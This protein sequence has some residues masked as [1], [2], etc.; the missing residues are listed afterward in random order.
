M[1]EV[2]LHTVQ[3]GGRHGLGGAISTGPIG[4]SR[5]GLIWLGSATNPE[6]LVKVLNACPQRYWVFASAGTN[7]GFTLYVLD[8]VTG[9]RKAY[10]NPDL[11][12]VPPIQDTSAL[13]CS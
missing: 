13:S 5:G 12:A 1:V 9:E 3:S 7:Q 6:V 8:T 10:V 4:V 2:P 11:K